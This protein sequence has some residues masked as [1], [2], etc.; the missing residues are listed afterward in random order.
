[1]DVTLHSLDIL[2]CCDLDV[3]APKS[4]QSAVCVCWTFNSTKHI[5]RVIDSTDTDRQRET[6]RERQVVR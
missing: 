2:C 4:Y 1:M 5:S 3:V 6:E